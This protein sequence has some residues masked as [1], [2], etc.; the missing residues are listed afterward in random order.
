MSE[1]ISCHGINYGN[2]RT[3][4]MLKLFPRENHVGLQ[5]FGEDGKAMAKRHKWPRNLRQN[6]SISIWVVRSEKSSPKVVVRRF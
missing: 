2:E 1:L 6:L 4:H 3:R 5:L